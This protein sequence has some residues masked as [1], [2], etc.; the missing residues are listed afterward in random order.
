MNLTEN[1]ARLA[2]AA[3]F[4]AH[5]VPLAKARKLQGRQEYFPLGGESGLGS[6]FDEPRVRVMSADDFEFPG[7]GTPE[8]LVDHLVSSWVAEGEPGLAAMG[9]ALKEISVAL[10]QEAAE[11]G[12]DVSILCYTMF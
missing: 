5:V 2:A 12:G 6:F 3:L 8:G 11:G 10:R 9:P 1:P 4:D 7:G